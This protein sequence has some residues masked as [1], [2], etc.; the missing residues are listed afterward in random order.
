MA[1]ENP[2]M[3]TQTSSRRPAWPFNPALVLEA[4][5]A[6]CRGMDDPNSMQVSLDIDQNYRIPSWILIF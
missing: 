5:N 3:T 1:L 6:V 4:F 2:A